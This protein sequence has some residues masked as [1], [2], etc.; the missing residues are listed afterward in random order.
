M[1]TTRSSTMPLVKSTKLSEITENHVSIYKD[2]VDLLKP[3]SKRLEVRMK[4]KYQ[5]ELWTEHEHRA[6][7]FHPRRR[8][9][10][11]FAGIWICK[12]HVG[13]YFYPLHLHEELKESI[14]V[15]LQAIMKGRSAFHFKTFHESVQNQ[16]KDLLDA[17]FKLFEEKGWI[18]RR[19]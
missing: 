13:F 9:G 14:P 10:V 4:E 18:I 15:E 5:Y 19:N 1:K 16:M 3:Y 11:L 12:P 7:S 8:H 2:L 6:K 17:G